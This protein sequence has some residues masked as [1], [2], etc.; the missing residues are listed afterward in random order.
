MSMSLVDRA[1]RAEEFG[2]ERK[3]PAQDEEFVL[4]PTPTTCRPRASSNT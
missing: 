3:G 1:L 4:S 2:E